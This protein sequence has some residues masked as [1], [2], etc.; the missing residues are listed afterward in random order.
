MVVSIGS[1]NGIALDTSVL[2]G[3]TWTTKRW[4]EEGRRTRRGGLAKGRGKGR[5]GADEMEVAIKGKRRM[6]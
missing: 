1:G 4:S 2:V 3:A 5:R 6:R